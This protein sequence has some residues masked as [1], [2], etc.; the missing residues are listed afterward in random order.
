MSIIFVLKTI[1]NQLRENMETKTHILVYAKR[2]KRTLLNFGALTLISMIK[3]KLRLRH[4]FDQII[5]T[6]IFTLNSYV[7][8]ETII[9]YKIRIAGRYQR[10]DRS[11]LFCK[12]YGAVSNGTINLKIDFASHVLK[13]RYGVFG[14]KYG[15]IK[16]I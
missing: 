12:S 2:R 5:K 1:L 4:R 7:A 11:N 8:T 9:G 16:V 13:G 14:V 6:L 15:F 10:S 3:L